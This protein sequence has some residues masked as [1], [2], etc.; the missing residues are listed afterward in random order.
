M[1]SS[2]AK[3]PENLRVASKIE[4]KTK[5]MKPISRSRSFIVFIFLIVYFHFVRISSLRNVALAK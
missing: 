1:V 5:M 2:P 4:P 3:A